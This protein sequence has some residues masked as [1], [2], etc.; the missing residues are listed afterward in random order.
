MSK[1]SHMVQLTNS[2]SWD[3]EWLRGRG[4]LVNAFQCLFRFQVLE[5]NKQHKPNRTET[6]LKNADE[7]VRQV[8]IEL[9]GSE[10][11]LGN[12]PNRA[13]CYPARPQLKH[14]PAVLSIA[15]A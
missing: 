1:Q 11:T 14:K 4:K 7:L 6:V 3:K 10:I 9:L 13:Q 12:M 8:G 15:L 5:T 2:I